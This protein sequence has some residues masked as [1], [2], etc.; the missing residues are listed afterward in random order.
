M[1]NAEPINVKEI[2]YSKINGREIVLWGCGANANGISLV[3]SRFG[4]DV[5]F[6]VDRDY[7]KIPYFHGI[8]VKSK[9]TLSSDSHF[10]IVASVAHS[11]AI[12]DE[13]IASGFNSFQDFYCWYGSDLVFDG[14]KIGAHTSGWEA[15][16]SSRITLDGVQQI[17]RYTSINETAYLAHERYAQLS[18]AHILTPQITETLTGRVNIGN[19]VWIGANAF[20]NATKVKSIGDG[21]IIGTGAVVIEDVPPY[22]I[23]LGVPAKVKKY[24]FTE[25]EI[26]RLLRVKWWNWSDEMIQENIAL[27]QDNNLFFERFME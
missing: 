1:N 21:A 23:V 7:E 6:F 22:A 17:G 20:I 14:V 15:L 13:L 2:L 8:P 26:A 11:S 18:T 27:F 4:F 24:R 16:L 19:D 25:N 9:E 10:V 12:A 3:L 5:S